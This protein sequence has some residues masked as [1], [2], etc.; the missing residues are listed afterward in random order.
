M[1]AADVRRRFGRSIRNFLVHYRPL[2]DSWTLYDNTTAMPGIVA[3]GERGHL[4][5]GEARLYNDLLKRYAK[6]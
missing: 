5:V 1:P 6:P 4:Q 2:A 3:S